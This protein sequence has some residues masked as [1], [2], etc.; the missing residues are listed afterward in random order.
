MVEKLERHLTRYL[1]AL[2]LGC[3]LTVVVAVLTIF[4]YRRKYADRVSFRLAFMLICVDVFLALFH[5]LDYVLYIPSRVC[6]FSAWGT[7]TCELMTIFLNV[8][9]AY[10]LQVVFLQEK[11]N[12]KQFEKLFVGGSLALAVTLSSIVAI[13]G[14]LGYDPND[15]VACWYINVGTSPTIIYEWTCELSWIV[16]ELWYLLIVISL[17][18]HKL[19]KQSAML[20]ERSQNEC[21]ET[22]K[23][24]L[25]TA[26]MVNYAVRRITLYPLVPLLAH[27]SKMITLIF[28][29]SGTPIPFWLRIITFSL[30]VSQGTLDSIVFLFDPT[31]H[32]IWTEYKSSRQQK[33][34]QQSI[35]TPTKNAVQIPIASTEELTY[36]PSH[37]NISSNPIDYIKSL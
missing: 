7:L 4:R 22:K 25:Y 34:K 23:Q 11:S 15:G 6:T 12:I 9:I 13:G 16:L 35:Y 19:I 26:K 30:I 2:S 5:I 20:R 3:S 24:Q 36:Q 27:S 18:A 33:M 29:Y 14:K 37:G 31:L 21:F 10:N 17:V 8:T 32:A 1:T 28:S